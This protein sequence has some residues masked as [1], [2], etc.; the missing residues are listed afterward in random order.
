MIFGKGFGQVKQ[1]AMYQALVR[2]VQ[3]GDYNNVIR[4]ATVLIDARFALHVVYAF[5]G[6]A[7]CNKGNYDSALIDLNQAIEA[8]EKDL[9]ALA[10]SLVNRG[11]CY[12]QQGNP[13][14]AIQDCSRAIEVAT[15][16]VTG[17]DG[18]HQLL[19]YAYM[20][21][22]MAYSTKGDHRQALAD[23]DNALLYA[24]TAKRDTQSFVYA[25]R[26]SVIGAQ[27]DPNA[28]L[29]DFDKALQLAGSQPY[30]KAWA[31]WRRG[32]MRAAQGDRDGAISDYSAAI[33]ACP[34]LVDPYHARAEQFS[35]IGERER[36]NTDQQKVIELRGDPPY[37]VDPDELYNEMVEA[38]KR[39][40]IN[41]AVAAFTIG[42]I[43]LVVLLALASQLR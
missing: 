20:N 42:L 2:H 32:L 13:D 22:G 12:R 40:P 11:H 3:N 33:A 15:Q 37:V 23:C 21:R 8:S 35:A 43:V 26:G 34:Q 17:V 30:P 7:R 39:R 25:D 18:Q 28:A 16:H 4:Y 9:F 38:G 31:Y 10:M 19:A 36:A 27:G 6:L 14:A 41:M 5:R 29:A 24:K 1:I